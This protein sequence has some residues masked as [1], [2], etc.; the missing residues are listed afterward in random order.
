[1]SVAPPPRHDIPRLSSLDLAIETGRLRLRPFTD[2][3]VDAIWPTVSDPTFPTQ[4]TWAAH[5]DKAETLAFIESTRVGIADD[6]EISWA[7]E[8]EGTV[9][10]CVSLLGIRWRL[11]SLR[12]DRADLGYWIARP[13]WGQGLMTEAARAAVQFAFDT[14]GL[15]KIRVK[16]FETN[17]GSRRV[18]EKLGFRYVGIEV[19]DA[20]RVDRWES[21]VLYEVT[22]AEWSDVS[23]TMPINRLPLP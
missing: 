2:D 18:I 8:H 1:M 12:F 3:D 11:R 7:I 20:W 14:L 23:T 10:G 16:A 17:A 4:M 6:T 5:A 19:D 22:S 9:V 15:H 13:R 21:H